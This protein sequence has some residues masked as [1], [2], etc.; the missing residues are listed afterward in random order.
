MCGDVVCDKDG[1]GALAVAAEM[2]AHV[3]KEGK[4]LARQLSDIYETYGEH[5]SNNGYYFC[6][7]PEKIT[8]MFDRI[9]HW[10]NKPGPKGYPQKLG[11]FKITGIRDLTVGYDDHYPDFKPV[12][13][14]SA[15]SQQ[16]TFDFS[17]G[18][19]LTIRIKYLMLRLVVRMLSVKA[20]DLDTPVCTLR[21]LLYQR[22]PLASLS[23]QS[24]VFYARKYLAEW[25]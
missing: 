24:I 15:S 12:L 25:N 7:E 10:P 8:Q 22:R 1:V 6:Y 17:N 14:V 11:Q 20:L 4:T 2:T 18:V 13:P 5:I 21:Y 3:Y 16:I 19:T 9:R 23:L